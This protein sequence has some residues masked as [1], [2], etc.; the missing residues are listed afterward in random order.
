VGLTGAY[1]QLQQQQ[2]Q[3][4]KLFQVEARTL[5]SCLAAATKVIVQSGLAVQRAVSG[6][7]VL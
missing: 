4:L 1:K 2:Q 3:P 5:S 7:P 6:Q